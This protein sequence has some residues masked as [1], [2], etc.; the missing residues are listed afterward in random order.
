MSSPNFSWVVGWYRLSVEI[1][2][3]CCI[4]FIVGRHVSSDHVEMI[5]PNDT[6]GASNEVASKMTYAEALM[7]NDETKKDENV[8]TKNERKVSFFGNNPN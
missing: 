2:Q 7:K 4:F 6:N 3:F 8:E 5:E 1:L